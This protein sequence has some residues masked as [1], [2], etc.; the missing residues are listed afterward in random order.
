[1]MYT[2]TAS[3]NGE[4]ANA[5]APSATAAMIPTPT[6]KKNNFREAGNFIGKSSATIGERRDQTWF[7]FTVLGRA[8]EAEF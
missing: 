6:D 5:T 3:K 1:M 4:N 8:V 2:P 7:N